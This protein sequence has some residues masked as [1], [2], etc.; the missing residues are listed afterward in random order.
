MSEPMPDR[1]VLLGRRPDRRQG[2]QQDPFVVHPDQGDM[3]S[4]PHGTTQR[5]SRT[6]IAVALCIAGLAAGALGGNLVG[7][8]AQESAPY[9]DTVTPERDLAAA[10]AQAPDDPPADTT[11]T[12]PADPPADPPAT[13]TPE[14]T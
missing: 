9:T 2:T 12:T 11:P 4:G 7:A 6:R 8:G 1:N 14:T 5:A 13:T 3:K 10:A